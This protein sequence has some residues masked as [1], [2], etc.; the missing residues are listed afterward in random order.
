MKKQRLSNWRLPVSLLCV[1]LLTACGGGSG[2]GSL[3]ESVVT[4]IE[5]ANSS[6]Q[7]ESIDNQSSIFIPSTGAATATE[8]SNPDASGT[9]NTDLTSLF[10]PSIEGN[11][12]SSVDEIDTSQPDGAQ[13]S[14]GQTTRSFQV[15]LGNDYA[16]EVAPALPQAP[17]E[18]PE[19]D[20]Y[21]LITGSS[22]LLNDLLPDGS[23]VVTIRGTELEAALGLAGDFEIE[24][25]MSDEDST[26]VLDITGPT[27]VRQSFEVP[28]PANADQVL[29]QATLM[30]QLS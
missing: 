16:P 28:V 1:G 19:I 29:V 15:F 6:P 2:G 20:M 27:L 10:I 17:T 14:G 3:S 11:G 23:I 12:S 26:I 8:N 18:P 25:P 13:I 30:W 4:N 7:T 9:D 22:T 5:A 21:T 24:I